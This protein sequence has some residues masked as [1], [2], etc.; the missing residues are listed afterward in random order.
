L[1]KNYVVTTDKGKIVQGILGRRT[2]ETIV[3]RDASGAK[4]RVRTD[5][6]EEMEIRRR[7]L[8]PDG[9][10]SELSHNEVRDLLAYLQG[11]KSGTGRQ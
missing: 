6:I 11:L 7:S 1:K 3:L 4:L 10:L 5:A 8:M 9:L 2:K